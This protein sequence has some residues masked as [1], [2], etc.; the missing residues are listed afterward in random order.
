MHAQASEVRVNRGG[1]AMAGARFLEILRCNGVDQNAV[2]H[3]GM[4]VPFGGENQVVLETSGMDVEVQNSPIKLQEFDG[5]ELTTLLLRG[6]QNA[7]SQPDVDPQ[8]RDAFMPATGWASHGF[9]GSS[10]RSRPDSRERS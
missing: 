9:S 3:P 10:A 5:R 1:D 2:P 8:Q 4:V 6:V 7:L